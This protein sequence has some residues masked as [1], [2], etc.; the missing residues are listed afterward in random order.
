MRA[1]KILTLK[2][3]SARCRLDTLGSWLADGVGYKMQSRKKRIPL[4]DSSGV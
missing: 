1:Q 2:S 4:I 3:S